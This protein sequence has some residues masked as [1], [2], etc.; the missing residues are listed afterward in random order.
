MFH[1]RVFWTS[2][3]LYIYI[4]PTHSKIHTDKNVYQWCRYLD[5]WRSL[6]LALTA[7]TYFKYSS[8]VGNENQRN[9]LNLCDYYIEKLTI[10]VDMCT[11]TD[12]EW[13]IVVWD[14]FSH[15]VFYTES[16]LLLSFAL[17]F[18]IPT[19]FKHCFILSS[20][21]VKDLSSFLFIFN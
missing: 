11:T 2:F 20:S 10:Q 18:N 12:I 14:F 17:D 3:V 15:S 4:P 5:R 16:L 21:F 8:W 13:R 7:K 9:L 1:K 6:I 19:T